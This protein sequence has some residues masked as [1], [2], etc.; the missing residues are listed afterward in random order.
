LSAEPRPP[1]RPRASGRWRMFRALVVIAMIAGAAWLIS[2]REEVASWLGPNGGLIAPDNPSADPANPA[3]RADGQGL[4]LTS[5]DP[6]TGAAIE[7]CSVETDAI[8]PDGFVGVRVRARVRSGNALGSRFAAHFNDENRNHIF[9]GDSRFS[10]SNR[11]AACAVTIPESFD[12]VNVTAFIPCTAFDVE[13]GNRRLEMLPALFNSADRP[14]V[15][16]R[17]VAFDWDRGSV[18]LTRVRY[19]PAEASFREP[20]LTVNIQSHRRQAIDLAVVV[21]LKDSNGL[22]YPGH[23]PYV[24][25]SGERAVTSNCVMPPARIV[26]ATIE[27]PIRIPAALTP[28]GSTVEIVCYDKQARAWLTHSIAIKLP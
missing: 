22:T 5:R 20:T 11:Q 18:Y 23:A 3:D 2:D 4:P 12:P 16:G 24:N 28:P 8:D 7:N 13:P 1:V 10:D 21:R 14:I 9:S 6:A 26:D 25:A 15:I 19:D 27:L 17:A